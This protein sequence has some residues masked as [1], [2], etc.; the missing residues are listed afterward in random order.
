MKV[1]A[2]IVLVAVIA[3]LIAPAVSLSPAARLV[4]AGHALH[5]I[6]TLLPLAVPS[7][8]PFVGGRRFPGTH[9][10]AKEPLTVVSIIAL[11][12]VLLC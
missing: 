9:I 8:I 11:N 7:S 10:P 3:V 6:L 5:K 4:R 1:V 12:C 2:V